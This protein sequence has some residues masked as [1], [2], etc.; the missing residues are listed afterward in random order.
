MSPSSTVSRF[1]VQDKMEEVY[2]HLSVT[3]LRQERGQKNLTHGEHT[4]IEK[5]G[6]LRRCF[7]DV[8][9]IPGGNDLHAASIRRHN[10]NTYNRRQKQ[11]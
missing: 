10:V 3:L 1:S 7:N 5:L 11:T 4:V 8:C 6:I 2:S 9:S